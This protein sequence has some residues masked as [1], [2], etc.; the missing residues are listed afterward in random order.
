VDT[1]T[2]PDSPRGQ[3]KNI[4]G[5][6]GLWGPHEE[7]VAREGW[8][9]LGG[10]IV[11]T[12]IL[13]F[14][15]GKIGLVIGLGLSAFVAA[16]FRNPERIPPDEPDA[17]IS[18]ADGTVVRIEE[19]TDPVLDIKSRCVSIF[20]SGANVH[21]N[22]SPITGKI[23][24]IAYKPGKFHKADHDA[25]MFENERNC[26]SVE[27]K[28]GRQVTF[29]QVAGFFA[30]R[31]VCWIT[32]GM[33]V[34]RAQRIG[35]IRFGSRVDVYLPMD[36]QVAVEIGDKTRAGNS[37]IAYFPHDFSDD[38]TLVGLEAQTE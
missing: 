6:T 33:E 31:I 2:D 7:P 25:A 11:I 32:A 37:I 26:I 28:L 34:G 18:P 23:T 10:A 22:R 12:I 14:V 30:R 1:H 24:N 16:F 4:D 29:A 20:M 19:A 8:P 3:Q 17:I 35:L 5:A 38:E 21:V 13:F 9:F 36:V 15:T 27:D